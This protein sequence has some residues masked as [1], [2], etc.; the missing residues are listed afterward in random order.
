MATVEVFKHFVQLLCGGCG[1]EPKNPVDDMIGPKLIGRVEVSGLSR[2]LEGPDDDPG[3]I[4]AQIQT[5]A[6]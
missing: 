6:I 4:R 3:R 5:L 2:R 1:V